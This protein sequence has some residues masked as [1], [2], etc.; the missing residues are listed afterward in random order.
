MTD[1]GKTNNNEIV[2]ECDFMNYFPDL[3]SLLLT[4]KIFHTFLKC[5]SCWLWMMKY[6]L[7]KYV[8]KYVILQNLKPVLKTVTK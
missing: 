3:M 1:G 4:W 7:G 2:T 6:F 5:F 8:K